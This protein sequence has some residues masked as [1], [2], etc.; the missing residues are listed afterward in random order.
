MSCE[1]NVDWDFVQG[2]TLSFVAQCREDD[3]TTA[4]DLT[5]YTAKMQMR[6]TPDDDPVLSLTEISG[7]TIDAEAGDVT[8]SADTDDIDPGDYL[9]ELV[10]TS[11]GGDSYVLVR[12]SIE[13][14]KPITQ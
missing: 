11:G 6:S 14:L 10:I 1:S 7:I 2:C 13:I 4:I 5:G 12:G 9:F 3:R 8:V